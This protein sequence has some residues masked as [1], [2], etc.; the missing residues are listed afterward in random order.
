MSKLKSKQSQYGLFFARHAQ[1]T[2]NE[3]GISSGGESN[4]ELTS[5]GIA[6]ARELVNTLKAG[7]C[8]PRLIITPP[9][10]RNLHTARIIGQ[11]LGLD[12][13]IETSLTERFLGDWNGQLSAKTAS[14]LNQ[15]IAPPNGESA[16]KFKERILQSF[17]NLSR[18]YDRWPLIIGSRGSSRI[19][20]EESGTEHR[21]HL[22]NGEIVLVRL[23]LPME[24]RVA[25][26]DRI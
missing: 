8:T 4:P 18:F 3:S 19:L 11:E 6:Q 2:A 23:S 13:R 7:K 12:M 20:F 14:L 26:I 21:G 24:F 22:D 5:F 17:R 15:G 16:G 1:S 10:T 9:H 25:S